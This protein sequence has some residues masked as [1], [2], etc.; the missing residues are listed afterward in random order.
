MVARSSKSSIYLF[1]AVGLGAGTT[2]YGW[3]SA[4]DGTFR[5]AWFIAGAA[6]CTLSLLVGVHLLQTDQHRRRQATAR[7]RASIAAA[8]ERD[9][10]ARTQLR[11]EAEARRQ[12][13]GAEKTVS[14][15]PHARAQPEPGQLPGMSATAADWIRDRALIDLSER[16]GDLEASGDTRN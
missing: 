4:G 13:H 7:R 6:S 10:R 16:T 8:V 12:R 5:P 14:L 3:L 9:R 1:T 11:L 15:P 2:V